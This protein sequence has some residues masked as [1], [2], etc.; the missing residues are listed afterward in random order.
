MEITR[1]KEAL[2]IEAL[3][4][5]LAELLRQLPV[6]ADPNGSERASQRLYPKPSG[7]D[8]QLNREW[9]DYVRP[10]LQYLFQSA[11]ATVTADLASM[12]SEQ[13][14]DG[15]LTSRLSIPLAHAQQWL[16]TLNQARL[17]IAERHNFKEA[18]INDADFS[19]P[20]SARDLHLFQ[21]HFYG[22]LQELLLGGFHSSEQC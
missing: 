17:C 22:I 5:F 3:D 13:A 4:S 2:L 6:V 18:D 12:N 21:I 15:S 11:N 8:E 1:Y 19:V 9:A 7:A 16:S 10:E 20:R 14:E